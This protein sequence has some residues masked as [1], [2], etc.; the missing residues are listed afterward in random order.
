MQT[1]FFFVWIMERVWYNS[2][3]TPMA[4]REL[5]WGPFL[6]MLFVCKDLMISKNIFHGCLVTILAI[7][8]QDQTWLNN[9]TFMH[10]MSQQTKKKWFLSPWE[11]HFPFICH[12]YSCNYR[13]F[14]CG[15]GVLS[16]KYQNIVKKKML[17]S[18]TWSPKWCPQ[19]S[20]FIHNPK[21]FSLLS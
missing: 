17:I 2:S 12:V 15:A 18:V 7:F 20:S 21:I 13:N 9:S 6:I 10:K 4:K 19:M 3:T 14:H 11:A 16:T 5:I 1:A 8:G